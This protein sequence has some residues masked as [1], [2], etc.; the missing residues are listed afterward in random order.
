MESLQKGEAKPC[1]QIRI[2]RC[3]SFLNVLLSL[4]RLLVKE[5]KKKVLLVGA[6][7]R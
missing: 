3:D 5:K 4:T 7:K 6:N 1:I 2:G